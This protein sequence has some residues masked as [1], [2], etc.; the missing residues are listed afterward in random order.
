MSLD[1]AA[2]RPLSHRYRAAVPFDVNYLHFFKCRFTLRSGLRLSLSG[3]R[4]S[5]LSGV[6]RRVCFVRPL[7]FASSLLAYDFR[8]RMQMMILRLILNCFSH[9]I[10]YKVGSSVCL[11]RGGL[12]ISRQEMPP[13]YP[14]SCISQSVSLYLRDIGFKLH[15]LRT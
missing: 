9:L 11:L 7:A 4:L 15:Q 6:W 10:N 13:F 3:L 1:Q 8:S 5:L 12:A 14:L 2:K